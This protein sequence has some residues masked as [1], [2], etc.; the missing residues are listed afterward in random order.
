MSKAKRGCFGCEEFK[1]RLRLTVPS[2]YSPTQ[3]QRRISLNMDATPENRAEAQKIIKRIHA[4]IEIRKY[5][6]EKLDEY[7]F[8]EPETTAKTPQSTSTK[9]PSLDELWSRYVAQKSKN[10]SQ[11][12]IWNTIM[13]VSSHINK[14][15]TKRLCDALEIESELSDNLTYPSRYRVL[16]LISTCCNWAVHSQIILRNPFWAIVDG[17]KAPNSDHDPDPF[18]RKDMERIIEAFKTH[19]RYS[20]LAPLV[21]FLFLTGCRTG[22]AVGLRWKNVTDRYIY[23]RESLSMARGRHI[24]KEGTKTQASREFPRANPRLNQLLEQLKPENVNPDDFVLQKPSGGHINR[25]TFYQNWYG[26]KHRGGKV[27]KGIVSKLASKTEEEG[28]IDHYRCPYSTRHTFI[29]LSLET[30]AEKRLL[31]PSDVSQLAKYVGNSAATI[32]KHYLGRSGNEELVN[33]DINSPPQ[34]SADGQPSYDELRAQLAAANQRLAQLSESQQTLTPSLHEPA[35]VEP[36]SMPE[37]PSSEPSETVPSLKVN[38]K[39]VSRHNGQTEPSDPKFEQLALW[40][41]LSE[42]VNPD[43]E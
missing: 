31:T 33:I 29:T 16:N 28:G 2:K 11:T 19:P 21:E 42:M 25:K 15:K 38:K 34:T 7:I 14:L 12:Y 5:D 36:T 17:L 32:Y 39:A 30:M 40:Q 4:Y 26:E 9:E 10:W 43:G 8:G 20:Y 35:P 1:G 27:Y 37:S 22:E 41:A 18:L 24:H 13:S 23:F 3:T 6:P